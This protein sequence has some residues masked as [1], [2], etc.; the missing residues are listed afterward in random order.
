MSSCPDASSLP[1]RKHLILDETIPIRWLA[2][3]RLTKSEIVS[4]LKSRS[5]RPAISL[6]SLS[7]IQIEVNLLIV[8][9]SFGTKS[10]DALFPECRHGREGGEILHPRLWPLGLVVETIAAAEETKK[11]PA[12]AIMNSEDHHL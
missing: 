12:R 2:L 1:Y 6:I 11:Y 8:N 5:H 9:A 3:V 7:S 10:S 4:P